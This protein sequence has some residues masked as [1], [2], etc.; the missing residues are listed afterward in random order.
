MTKISNSGF[1]FASP[2]VFAVLVTAAVGSIALGS[3]GTN[4]F[5][6]TNDTPNGLN[7]KSP[8]DA[9]PPSIDEV[10]SRQGILSSYPRHLPGEEPEGQSAIILIPTEDNAMYSGMLNYFS[11]RPVDVIAWN[12][13]QSGNTSAI[14]DEFGN[15]EDYAFSGNETIAFTTL[16]SG[17]SGSVPFNADALEI[18]SAGGG[19][20]GSDSSEEP[21]MVAYSLSAVPYQAEIVNNL[22]TLAA[23]VDSSSADSE[24]EGEEESH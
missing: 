5:A 9:T 13:M 10:F 16:G 1:L 7:S 19:G 15:L 8:Y 12:M 3:L 2:I 23:A 24:G 20:D 21:F 22:T 4:S 17:T 6:Q 18:V 11:S 14:S